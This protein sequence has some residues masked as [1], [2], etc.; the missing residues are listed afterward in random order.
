MTPATAPAS[1]FYPP[2]QDE[3][4]VIGEKDI[5]TLGER[6]PTKSMDHTD[7]ASV[8]RNMERRLQQQEGELASLRAQ[9]NDKGQ[10]PADGPTPCRTRS[11][12][13][14]G[15]D[16]EP[17]ADQEYVAEHLE[18][19]Y[20]YSTI[21]SYQVTDQPGWG[22]VKLTL[23]F[24][25]RM[26][27]N[28]FVLATQLMLAFAYWDSGV[29]DLVLGDK[30]VFSEPVDHSLFRANA[31]S[32]SLV[33]TVNVLASI[34]SIGLLAISTSDDTTAVLI[35][36]T[37][38][39]ISFFESERK[40][41]GIEEE[42]YS[43]RNSKS[44][45]H[46]LQVVIVEAIQQSMITVRCVI[47]PTQAM[48]GAAISFASSDDAQDI[49]LNSS[50]I[51][52]VL[53]IDELI[54]NW[55]VRPSERA[56]HTE[57]AVGLVKRGDAHAAGRLQYIDQLFY[58]RA[59][60]FSLDSVFLAIIYCS[61]SGLLL[62]LPSSYI[63]RTGMDATSVLAK[64]VGNRVLQM[65][66][67][68][69]RG[70]LVAAAQASVCFS[71]L[72]RP[73]PARFYLYLIIKLSLGC[74]VTAIVYQVVIQACLVALLGCNSSFNG[75][76]FESNWIRSGLGHPTLTG[77]LAGTGD[78]DVCMNLHQNAT[79]MAYLA[80]ENNEEKSVLA[81]WWIFQWPNTPTHGPTQGYG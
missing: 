15:A 33:P 55:I 48:S 26:L 32:G 24:W 11:P 7:I 60:F 53:E 43:K 61:S 79:V 41:A 66:Y 45:L 23:W 36:P 70:I 34:A 52:F 37:L 73:V 31:I 44:I 74:F 42:S 65:I 56:V 64:L 63:G 17:T 6:S 27:L 35:V 75:P 2:A 19:M 5:G 14:G 1:D 21:W 47:V 10:R 3:V 4:T 81:K 50:A 30:V 39:E 58:W 59:L 69:V 18:N 9:L 25:S 46:Y 54:Y 40:V 71:H 72:P 13:D 57:K 28:I 38:L 8:V 12:S 80:E 67:A 20:E 68:I 51:A 76:H 78:G 62:A 77:C 49:V 29:L 22:N 16:E